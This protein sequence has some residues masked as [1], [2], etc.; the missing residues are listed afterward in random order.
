MQDYGSWCLSSLSERGEEAAAFIDFSSQPEIQALMSRQIGTAPL[1][2][3][4]D[5]G[6][7]DEEFA[8]VSGVPSIT[9]AYEAY[10]D[11]ETF[12]QESWDKMLAGA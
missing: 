3:Q 2:P 5:A 12:I 1:M 9:P 10:L 8:A 11:E 4:A 7:T 6:L